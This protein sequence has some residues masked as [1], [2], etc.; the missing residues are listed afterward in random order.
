M[1]SDPSETESSR[2]PLGGELVAPVSGGGWQAVFALPLAFT[3]LFFIA[4]LCPPVLPRPRLVWTAIAVGDGLL[5]WQIYIFMGAA[6]AG[7]RLRIEYRVVKAHYVQALVQLS[8]YAY[9]G[10]YWRRVYSE[11][12]LI[13]AQIVFLYV[14][15]ALL[16]WSRGR[17]WRL[18]F[19]PF[20]I[21]LSTNL[22]MWFRDDW[23]VFQFLM[24]ATGAL[25]KEFIQ[26]ERGGRKTHIFN[27]SALGLALF[28][29]GLLLTGTSNYTWGLQ[30]ATTLASPPFIY[31][32][33]FLAGLVVQGFFG[34][35]LITSAA[36]ATL[37]VANLIFTHFTGNYYFGDAYIPIAVFLG[38]HLL[39][40]DPATSPKT[41]FGK[42][43]FGI[44][45][46]AGTWITFGILRHFGLPDFYDKLL[47]VPLLNLSVMALDRIANAGILGRLSQWET[48]I[49]QR[50]LNGA[51]MGCW[52][53]LF[54]AMLTTKFVEAPLPDRG[55]GVVPGHVTHM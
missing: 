10:W 32:E 38:F 14:F 28:S 4:M 36:A 53:L 13:L 8:V 35:T 44:G 46:G 37:V 15:D 16:S 55:T 29:A 21:I 45:Y 50:K 34:I 47:V 33:I 39:V 26:W 3:V 6:R 41:S 49:D 27:P 19:G 11:A 52:G 9:W 23:F 2:L 1:D 31:C 48:G 30:I 42:M 20:P 24:I 7:R 12:H 51:F 18:G 17:P 40:T 43:L 22:F 5:L 54:A 25:A